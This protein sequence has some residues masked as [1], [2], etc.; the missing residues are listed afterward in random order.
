MNNKNLIKRL[1]K[2]PITVKQHTQKIVANP[3]VSI[4]VQTYQQ[5]SFIKMC[6]DSILMQTTEF[7]YEILIGE[8]ESSDDT[9]DICL[10]YADRHPDKIRLFLHSRKN[11]IF[12]KDKPTGRFN[13]VYN[14]FK[15]RGKYIAFLEGDD[16]WIDPYKLQKQAAFLEKNKDFSMCFGQYLILNNDTNRIK[17]GPQYRKNIFTTTDL[18]QGYNFIHI[19][20]GLYKKNSILPLP[21]IFVKFPMGDWPLN[22][23]TSLHGKIFCFCDNFSV[24]RRHSQNTWA[25]TNILEQRWK[26]IEFL[27]LLKQLYPELTGLIQ[28]RVTAILDEM[29]LIAKTSTR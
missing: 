12:I 17:Q 8:D 13:L 20:T 19:S 9:R 3:L 4:C 29:I 14:L 15:A 2:A 21:E 25:N 6:L 7:E 26:S 23:I 27:L 11:V 16:F 10:E 28:K 1:Q 24:Y 18:L 22:I 5:S